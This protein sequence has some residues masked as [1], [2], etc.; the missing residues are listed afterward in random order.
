MCYFPLAP[1]SFLQL[2]QSG[3]SLE[4]TALYFRSTSYYGPNTTLYSTVRC[5]SPQSRVASSQSLDL[6]L[7]IALC[8]E[9]PGKVE[10]ADANECRRE[11]PHIGV[12]RDR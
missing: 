11:E 9:A 6:R 1:G 10:K 8:G 2:V 5:L 12:Q 3:P 7:R 4:E